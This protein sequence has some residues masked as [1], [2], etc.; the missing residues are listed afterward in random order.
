MCSSKSCMNCFTSCSM[1]LS[2]YLRWFFAGLID[3]PGP[4]P[5]SI[6]LPSS[7]LSVFDCLCYR[8]PDGTTC[9]SDDEV[10]KFWCLVGSG[11]NVLGAAFF[12]TELRELVKLILS[13][14][15]WAPARTS[16]LWGALKLDPELFITR[17]CWE[18]GAC[19]A[20]FL[21]LVDVCIYCL[22]FLVSSSRC[23]FAASI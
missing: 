15:S 16:V 22:R 7:L 1:F 9:T 23:F 13:R 17:C 11:F 20:I 10:V 14:S 18:E 12:L 5:M 6:T 19:F 3:L 21:W 4:R 8:E 2:I